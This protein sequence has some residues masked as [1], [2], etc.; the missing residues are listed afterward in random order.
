MIEFYDE[1]RHV[2]WLMAFASGGLLFIHGLIHLSQADNLLSTSVRYLR[3]GVDTVLITAAL[4]LTNIVQQFPF[5]DAWLTVKFLLLMVYLFLSHIM[6]YN[7]RNQRQ[8]VI[9]WGL[10]LM[11]WLFI[12]S[13]AKTHNS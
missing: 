12:F 2:H 6:L 9:V 10:A 13:V 5:I 1:V 11:T 7:T 8:Y 4:M 3:Y